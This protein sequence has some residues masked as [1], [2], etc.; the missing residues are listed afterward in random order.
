MPLR[1]GQAPVPLRTPN[2]F[3]RATFASHPVADHVI[4]PDIDDE[5]DSLSASSSSSTDVATSPT[6]SWLTIYQPSDADTLDNSTSQ[7]SSSS[8]SDLEAMASNDLFPTDMWSIAQRA[9][10]LG[11][12]RYIVLPSTSANN[13]VAARASHVH[14]LVTQQILPQHHHSGSAP[15][16]LVVWAT[17]SRAA[18]SRG[19]MRGL[20][21]SALLAG[22]HPDIL[23]PGDVWGLPGETNVPNARPVL[24]CSPKALLRCEE[25]ILP[26]NPTIVFAEMPVPDLDD[27]DDD[28]SSDDDYDAKG[29]SRKLKEN[30][31][32]IK[33]NSRK[34]REDRA[35]AATAELWHAVAGFAGSAGDERSRVYTFLDPGAAA[36]RR[37]A[38]RLR[39]KMRLEGVEVP[40]LV[41]R[42]AEAGIADPVN[43]DGDGG[44]K[45]GGDKDGG[46]DGVECDGDPDEGGVSLGRR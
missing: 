11:R 24:S 36:D 1:L 20:F 33:I 15:R 23:H 17:A 31:N 18:R 9:D 19:I 32:K 28:D 8:S 26:L 5:N 29:T 43:G 25:E 40:P 41:A 27:D 45:D 22:T 37:V 34:V 13:T 35:A 3:A 38:R 4:A 6:V 10:T 42:M 44:D 30:R 14:A 7:M 12:R 46:G 39:S 16:I 2:N 21:T